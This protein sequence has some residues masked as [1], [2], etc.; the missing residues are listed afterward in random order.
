MFG[1]WTDLAP[2][3]AVAA[4]AFWGFGNYFIIAPEIG[5][6][7]ARA[8][9][10]PA[11]RANI[12]MVAQD[13]ADRAIAELPR[14]HADLPQSMAAAQLQQLQQG[15]LGALLRDPAL[16]QLFGLGAMTDLAI[17]EIGQKKR[18]AADAYNQGVE[19][20][21][22]AAQARIHVADDVCG[23]LADAELTQTRNDWTIFT[24]TLGL[25]QPPTV[26]DFGTRIL[27]HS[28]AACGK[29]GA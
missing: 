8:D 24:A 26:R 17:A 2:K 6:R 9:H 23:C 13:Q 18:A 1:S 20:I 5:M 16:D 3:T 15:P 14:S 25:I 4:V 27:Q 28:A 7:I 22:Q 10:L 19:Q 11:C 29:A 21:R 12:E